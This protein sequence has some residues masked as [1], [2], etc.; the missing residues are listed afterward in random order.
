MRNKTFLQ[1][2]FGLTIVVL[3]LAGCGGVP[4][5]PTATPVSTFTLTPA[6]TFTPTPEFPTFTLDNGLEITSASEITGEG[7]VSFDVGT[8]KNALKITLNGNIPVTDPEAICWFCLNIIH[9][10][11]DLKVPVEFFGVLELDK[12]ATINGG[13]LNQNLKIVEVNGIRVIKNPPEVESITYVSLVLDYPLMPNSTNAIITGDHGVTLKKEG[14]LFFLV[15]G[16]AHLEK[17]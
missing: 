11:P 15:E 12:T 9:I 7:E 13:S 4:V 17:K 6:P 10:G 8:S 5:Q 2:A 16:S 3:L 14:K 1:Q